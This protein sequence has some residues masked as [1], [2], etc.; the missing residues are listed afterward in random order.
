M[1]VY[2]KKKNYKRFTKKSRSKK[3]KKSRKNHKKQYKKRRQK[4]GSNVTFVKKGVIDKNNYEYIRFNENDREWILLKIPHLQQ[5]IE[6][7]KIKD[8][9]GQELVVS[10][11][12]YFITCQTDEDLKKRYDEKSL[13]KYILNTDQFYKVNKL[14]EYTI[15][16]HPSYIWIRISYKYVEDFWNLDNN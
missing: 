3:S 14:E 15:K 8:M 1:G 9:E 7:K 4:G 2:T 10:P 6:D 12:D 13:I 16:N 11:E 5:Y